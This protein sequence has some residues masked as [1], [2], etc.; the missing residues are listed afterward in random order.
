MKKGER[1]LDNFPR[2]SEIHLLARLVCPNLFSKEGINTKQTKIKQ[3]KKRNKLLYLGLGTSKKE[4][5][6]RQEDKRKE[7]KRCLD[8]VLN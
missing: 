4:E 8:T 7:I 5:K 6:E 2:K 3:K 1:H